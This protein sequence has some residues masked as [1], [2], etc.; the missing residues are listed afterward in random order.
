MENAWWLD[1]PVD[2]G[3]TE[4]GRYAPRGQAQAPKVLRQT[5]GQGGT[6]LSFDKVEIAKPS[7]HE[8][9]NAPLKF[10]HE[11]REVMRTASER[12][13]A[14]IQ[15]GH[16]PL[17][18]G[19]DHS[20]S[21]ATATGVSRTLPENQKLGAIVF[22]AHTDFNLP[23]PVAESPDD[24]QPGFTF[25]GNAHGMIHALLGRLG[26][27][28]YELAGFCE[29]YSKLDPQRVVVIG[30]R[31]QRY[32][33]LEKTLESARPFL[34]CAE[35]VKV[36]REATRSALMKKALERATRDFTEPFYVSWDVDVIDP[37]DCPAVATPVPAGLSWLE[38]EDCLEK[39]YELE[40][41]KAGLKAFEVSE[42]CPS[43][44][45][46]EH[47]AAQRIVGIMAKFLAL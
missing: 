24:I 8:A 6:G 33:Q 17:V 19:G 25:S 31:S 32:P 9:W 22:D 5:L 2:F 44:D 26:D 10:D 30:V 13:A 43:L 41:F 3:H 37:A 45:T 39:L 29:H 35:E 40:F 36:S 46:A 14:A 34:I 7:R 23:G 1:L 47:S 38:M 21:L 27:V 28:K 15:S 18:V 42:Y 12:I 11:L 20:I 4:R 16:F